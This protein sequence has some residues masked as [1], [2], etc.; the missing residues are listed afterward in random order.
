[1]WRWDQQEPFGVNPADENP[2]G[3]GAFDLP[4]RLPGQYFDKETNLHYNYFRDY[5]P[6]LGIYKQSDLIGLDG[7]INTYAYAY[8]SP[9]SNFDASGL[10]V[11]I[12]CRLLAPAGRFISRQIF[13]RP[14]RHCFLYVGCPEEDWATVLSVQGNIWPL[15]V[16]STGRKVQASP[17]SPVEG[18]D[19]FS[20][21][22]QTVPV[23]PKNPGCVPCGYEKEIITKF[24]RIPSGNIPYDELGPNSNTF[25]NYLATSSTFGA[26][27][28]YSSIPNAPGL[29]DS[30]PNAWR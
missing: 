10:F 27:V 12:K 17:L 2:S 21:A 15:P 20:P 5:D 7:G 3:L 18:D 26:T 22:V 8:G 25:V 29:S 13:G 24:N 30:P 23:T 9:L 1:M 28:P 14:Q 19:P 4:L 16:F 11:E 6:S